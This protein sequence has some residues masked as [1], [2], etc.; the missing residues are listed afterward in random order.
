MYVFNRQK[1]DIELSS[2]D[3]YG[4]TIPVG[5]SWIY[6]IAGKHLLD[7]IY[8]IETQPG[9]KK[10][11]K[12][13]FDNGSGVPPLLLSTEEKWFEEGKKLTMVKRFKVNGKQVPRKALVTIAQQR[14]VQNNRVLEYLADSTIDQLMIAEDINN[15]PVPEEVRCPVNLEADAPVSQVVPQ[16]S[17]V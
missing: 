13:G 6:E 3:G 1:E 9:A 7:N 4:F 2:F 10:A 16:V 11:D 8:K 12:Y 14:G 5:G 15:L 17:K